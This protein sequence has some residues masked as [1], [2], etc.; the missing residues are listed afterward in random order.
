MHLCSAQNNQ[1]TDSTQP[2]ISA[3]LLDKKVELS[4]MEQVAS[5][6]VLV[7]NCCLHVEPAVGVRDRSQACFIT[8]IAV[9]GRITKKDH[10]QFTAQTLLLGSVS[11]PAC[12]TAA[13]RVN[14]G[15]LSFLLATITNTKVYELYMLC[16]ACCGSVLGAVRSAARW[17]FRLRASCRTSHADASCLPAL[18]RQACTHSGGRL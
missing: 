6:S 5:A 12:E 8:Y 13:V 14:T 11:F 16:Y 10:F 2:K 17:A 18:V 7:V 15:L 4:G 9:T 1:A 3:L